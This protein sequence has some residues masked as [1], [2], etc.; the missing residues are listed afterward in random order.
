VDAYVRALESRQISELRRVYPAMSPEQE[1]QLS[2][3]LRAMEQ[4][5]VTM[6]VR[7]LDIRGTSATAMV[8]GTYDFYSRDS[9]RRERLPVNVQMTLEQGAS[10]WLIRQIRSVR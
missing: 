3:A 6:D 4:L 7:S 2:G 8:S 1:Q 5:D 9:R 10:G